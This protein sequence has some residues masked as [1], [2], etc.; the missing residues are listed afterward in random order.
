MQLSRSKEVK[1]VFRPYIFVLKEG[2]KIQKD[3]LD[4]SLMIFSVQ[5]LETI[6]SP[7]DSM[8]IKK[9]SKVPLPF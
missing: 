6:K 7:T 3:L 1:P 2:K 8:S 4:Y 9:A 5:S